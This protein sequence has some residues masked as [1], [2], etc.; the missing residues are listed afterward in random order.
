ML[1]SSKGEEDDMSLAAGLR[2]WRCSSSVLHFGGFGRES[3]TR[4]FEWGLFASVGGIFGAAGTCCLAEDVPGK[5]REFSVEE[6]SRHRN[7]KDGIWVSYKG[8]V[9]DVTEF[10]EMHPGGKDKI[11]LAAGGPLEP[12]WAMYKQHEKDFVQSII[13]EYYIGRLNSND[14]KLHSENLDSPYVNDP[15]RHPALLVRT[16]E[17]FN[18]ET[19]IQLVPDNYITPNDLFFVRNHL[20][21]PIVKDIENFRIQF[22]VDGKD[23]FGFEISLDELKKNYAKHSITATIQCAGNRRSDMGRLKEVKG[24]GW[25]QG[26]I[27]NA[28]WSGALLRDVLISKGFDLDKFPEI[29]HI[30]FEGLDQDMVGTKYGASIPAH[31]AMDTHGDV[32][33][34]Y[35]MNGVE[36]PLDHGFPV[37]AVVPGTVGARSVKWL[38]KITASTQESS[39]HWQQKD[40]KSFNPSVDWHNV[41][42]SKAVSIQEFPIQSAVCEPTENSVVDADEDFVLAKGYAVSGGGREVIRVDISTDGGETWM[43]AELLPKD[44]SATV[45]GR[46]WSWVLWKAKIPITEQHRSAKEIHIMCK[47]VDSAYNEQPENFKSIWNLRGLL[48]TAWHSIRAEIS[49]SKN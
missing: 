38:S 16:S 4:K 19:P 36:L 13:K 45:P 47:A 10:V 6:L 49:S 32:L 20:P 18:A 42:F 46:D 25:S 33:L 43:E 30:Q 41:D 9:Y 3:R 29:K 17:P 37:R 39:S 40:Y 8:N 26:A 44:K 21:V 5:D 35:E 14:A 28:S 22:S 24:T 7:A 48:S 2:F 34:A 12:F 15:I 27:S 23:S 1:A 11:M 31:K